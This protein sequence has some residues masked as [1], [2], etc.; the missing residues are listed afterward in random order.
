MYCLLSLWGIFQ[1]NGFLFDCL[2][3]SNEVHRCIQENPR[4]IH[5]RI[6][7]HN[8]FISVRFIQLWII[9][10]VP[11]MCE[12]YT[13]HSIFV[14]PFMT[15][16]IVLSSEFLATIPAGLCPLRIQIVKMWSTDNL[17]SSALNQT[18]NKNHQQIKIW[19]LTFFWIWII[20]LRQSHW[21]QFCKAEV[22]SNL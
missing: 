21:W 7:E 22:C 12:D 5:R 1:N 3:D 9:G 14:G 13:E 4:R 10:E 19:I 8:N 15:F 11:S 16:Q 20:R 17:P 2:G 18:E 6:Q